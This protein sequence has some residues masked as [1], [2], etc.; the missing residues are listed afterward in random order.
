[1][2]QF[3]DDINQRKNT[4]PFENFNFSLFST[5]PTEQG[6]HLGDQEHDGDS[7]GG[8]GLDLMYFHDKANGELQ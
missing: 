4:S 7:G 2:P 8:V 5:L 6:D 3:C 1:M